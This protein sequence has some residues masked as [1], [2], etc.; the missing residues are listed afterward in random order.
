MRFASD[1]ILPTSVLTDNANN[2]KKARQLTVEAVVSHDQE[3][4]PVVGGSI[5]LVLSVGC[6]AH[7]NG[8]TAKQLTGLVRK[9]GVITK[10]G[11]YYE[12]VEI[13]EMVHR[14][15]HASYPSRLYRGKQVASFCCGFRTECPFQGPLSWRNEMDVGDRV[16]SSTRYEFWSCQ[17][18]HHGNQNT[19]LE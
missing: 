10:Q 8:L 19:S 14:F 4:F 2:V 17:N 13:C 3:A 12:I 7:I 6:Y 11:Q 15:V 5:R 16:H 1:N 9:D 18:T